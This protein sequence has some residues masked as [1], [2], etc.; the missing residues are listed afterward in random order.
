M[1]TFCAKFRV[2]M[3]LYE[4]E[5]QQ[6]QFISFSFTFLQSGFRAIGVLNWFGEVFS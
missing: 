2:I 1:P 4:A 3:Y 6:E 5:V